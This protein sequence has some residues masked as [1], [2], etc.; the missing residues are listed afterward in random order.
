M[1][2][3]LKKNDMGRGVWEVGAFPYDEFGVGGQPT[4]ENWRGSP[5]HT[6]KLVVVRVWVGLVWGCGTGV[7]SD[8]VKTEKLTESVSQ[9]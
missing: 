3:F 9:I 2:G 6:R 1:C 5:T 4:Q 7:Y 8:A